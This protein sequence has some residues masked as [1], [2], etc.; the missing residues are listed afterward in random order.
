MQNV[1]YNQ[2]QEVIYPESS[3]LREG[4]PE[5]F[6]P[7]ES[8]PRWPSTPPPA[9]QMPVTLKSQMQFRQVQ[10]PREY[11]V[12]KDRVSIPAMPVRT[13]YP[14]YQSVENKT[15]PLVGYQYWPPAE[16][17][18][19][20]PPEVQY[21]SQAVCPVPNSKALYQQ[22]TATAFDPTA[23]PS[24]QGS[25]LHETIN[26]AG[27]QGDLEAWQYLV[28]LQQIP[29]GK[30]SQAGASARTEPRYESFTMKML[31]D[32]KEGVKQ[33]GLNSPYMRTLLDSIAHGNRLIPYDW[34]ILA[35]SSISPSQFLQFKTRWMDGVQEQVRKNQVTYPVV[36]IDADQLLGTGPNWSTINQQ[37]VM[38]NEATEQLRA[39]CLRAWEKIQDPGTT[40][41]SF[42]SIRR[43]SK[44]PHPDFVARLQDAVQNSIADD[45]ARKVVVEIMAYQNANPEFQSA[46]KPLRGKVPAGVDV[47]TEY[48]KAC[49][50]IVGAMQKAMLM[51]QAITG[52][53]LGGQVRTFGG[54]CY[55]CGQIGH[56][57]KN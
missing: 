2:L 47:I 52:I 27:K 11:Q 24:G 29:A 21:R 19:R 5:L 42:N 31:K 51:A 56:L 8:K 28:T 14:Q 36:N 18:Y 46:I 26:T 33:H 23:P 50:G 35:K 6:G 40:C 48:V 53:A 17:Q 45:N 44:E 15:Q 20:P 22:P 39:M 7:S 41:P 16:F 43:G 25:T 12:E 54:K 38:Q 57:K 10:T 37:S 9:V 4:G 30:G 55:N 3:K 13:Q 32:M 49:D 34:E 1:D